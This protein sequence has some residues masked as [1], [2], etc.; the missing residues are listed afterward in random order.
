MRS[1]LVVLRKGSMPLG[2]KVGLGSADLAECY[3]FITQQQA[4][5]ANYCAGIS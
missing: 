1:F 3:L 5:T 4:I 2:S